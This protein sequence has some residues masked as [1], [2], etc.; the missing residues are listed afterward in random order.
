MDT[1]WSMIL[2]LCLCIPIE[3][4]SSFRMSFGSCF[5]HKYINI[6]SLI[7]Q[8]VAADGPDCWVWLGTFAADQGTR[9]T[10]T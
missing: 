10:R 2:L 5:S 6:D 9:R 1:S 3:S 4:S 7:F 8:A